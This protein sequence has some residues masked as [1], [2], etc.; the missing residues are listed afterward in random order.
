ME[1][2]LKKNMKPILLNLPDDVLEELQE[3]SDL[4]GR[5]RKD[6]IEQLLISHARASQL[7]NQPEQQ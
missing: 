1:K 7:A 6:Y 2:I 3:L 4:N 5:K